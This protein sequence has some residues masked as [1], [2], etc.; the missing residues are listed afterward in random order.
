M[1]GRLRGLILEK[2][3]PW[4]VLDVAGVGYELEVSMSTFCQL[5]AEGESVLYTHLVVRE[6]AQLL[7][8]FSSKSERD[9]FRELIKISGVGPKVALSIL[10]VL[11]IKKLVMCVQEQDASALTRVPGIGKKTASRLL[12]EMQG[13]LDSWMGTSDEFSLSVMS[14][15]D[16]AL[17]TDSRQEIMDAINALISLGYKQ[18]E[19]S[20]AV[21]A[22]NKKRDLASEQ[23]IRQALQEMV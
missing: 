3:P 13:R 20:K 19:A 21:N 14:G 23:L 15:T 11:D 10:S 18:S 5:P 1:I 17:Q 9:V 12:V 6:D 2:S 16:S 22:I 4:V 8:G 7:Y